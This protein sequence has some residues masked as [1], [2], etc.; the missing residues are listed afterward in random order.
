MSQVFSVSLAGNRLNDHV[1]HGE[2]ENKVRGIGVER[3]RI[4]RGK[5]RDSIQDIYE[6]SPFL[7]SKFVSPL[8]YTLFPPVPRKREGGK[9][10]KGFLLSKTCFFWRNI[11]KEQRILILFYF[12]IYLLLGG[13]KVAGNLH[14][15]V[16][17]ISLSLFSKL[18]H[19]FCI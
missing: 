4:L 11:F 18:S 12:Y 7:T 3:G 13:C 2:K 5:G 15:R 10:R 1:D 9:C 8:A 6:V 14:P 17:R 19:I 16:K